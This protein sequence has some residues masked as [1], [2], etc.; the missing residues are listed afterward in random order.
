[1]CIRDRYNEKVYPFWSLPK[2]MDVT[3]EYAYSFE[4]ELVIPLEKLYKNKSNGRIAY[5]CVTNRDN[6]IPIDWTEYDAQHLAFRNVRN[7]TLMRVATYENG[8]LNFLT[9]PFYVDK[10]KNEQHYFSVEG[11]TQDVVLYAKL[12]LIHI[13]LYNIEALAAD[14]EYP[15]VSHC[16]GSGT[17]DCPVTHRKVEYI[18]GGLSLIHI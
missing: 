7:G 9:D 17:L 16:Y 4:K 11:D 13:F 15:L 6:W 18:A 10:Q 5:L 12:S 8:T 2:F 1:M 3:Y 14:D